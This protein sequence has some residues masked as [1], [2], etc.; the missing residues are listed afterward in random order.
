MCR[1]G[2]LQLHGGKG[3]E[4]KVRRLQQLTEQRRHRSRGVATEVLGDEA[5]TRRAAPDAYDTARYVRS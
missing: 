5:H 4:R 3:A 2:A 1:R